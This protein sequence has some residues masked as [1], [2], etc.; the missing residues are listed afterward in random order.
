[1]VRGDADQ[2]K[3]LCTNLLDTAIKYTPAPGSITFS[4]RRRNGDIVITLSDTGI[5]IAPDQLRRVYD[6]FWQ[7]DPARSHEDGSGQ[8]LR[9]VRLPL[10]LSGLSSR[11]LYPHLAKLRT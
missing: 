9:I 8:V 5:G 7:A 4:F 10:K 3:R 1:M 11:V 2:L 6:R